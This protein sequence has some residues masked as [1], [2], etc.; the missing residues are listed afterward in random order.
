M[1]ALLI[2]FSQKA[3]SAT[4]FFKPKFREKCEV[5]QSATLFRLK[6]PLMHVKRW[7]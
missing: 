1:I 5:F 3:E 6:N 4:L 7:F 2:P